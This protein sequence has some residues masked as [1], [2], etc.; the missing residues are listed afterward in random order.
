MNCWRFSPDLKK[1]SLENFQK[2][3]LFES[4]RMFCDLYCFEIDQEQK[5][6]KHDGS[7]KIYYV[8]E[9]EGI[10]QVGSEERRLGPG[11]AIWAPS[12]ED[13]GVRNPGPERLVT[14]VF[15]APPPP[16]KSK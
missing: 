9:G 14:L 6:H 2:V 13:H 16:K 3:N 10:F 7:D 15:M 11:Y 5:P 4:E 1:F 12:G 8:I